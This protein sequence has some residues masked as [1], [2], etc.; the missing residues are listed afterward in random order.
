MDSW[1]LLIRGG[2]IVAPEGTRRADIAIAGDKI[3]E[4]AADL[5]RH[6]STEIDAGG[7]HVF[8]GL[9]DA[10][11]HFN[12]PGR[13]EW[14][15][16]STGSSALAAGGGTCFFDMP[17]NSS[18]PTLDAASFHAKRRAAEAASHTDFALWGGVTP[19]NLDKLP[20]L[21][22][23]GVIGFKAF[24]AD[25]G[26]EDFPRS[27]DET[28]EQG[29]ISAAR[30]GLPVAVHAEDQELTSRL[31]AEA[32]AAERRGV[33]DFLAS[34]PI[35]AELSAVDR[36]IHIA[37]R[38]GCSLHVVHVSSPAAC[39]R[40]ALAK[41]NTQVTCETCP[42]YLAL[43]DADMQRIGAAA[44]CAPPLRSAEESGELLQHLLAGDFD[45]IGSD[46]SPAPESMKRSDDF[47]AVWGG[48]AGVQ[49]TLS[50]LLSLEPAIPLGQIA[51][52][53][54]ANVAKRFRLPGKGQLVTGYDADLA[55]VDL[56]STYTLRREQLLDRHKLSPYIGRK[57]RGVVRRTILRGRTILL[58]G[59]II[60]S[61]GR[62]RGRLVVPSPS[63][64]DP[65]QA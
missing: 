11:V 9:I 44:K 64:H 5:P 48:I 15:G 30:L 26:I 53:T 45:L 2:T 41:A 3:I 18:P 6:A 42:H 24:M 63:S 46:H 1:D 14:E 22:R 12:E 65:H 23:C 16:F 52:L 62:T 35:A 19:V 38:T 17:L 60:Q 59:Q 28:L 49:S 50:L 29:M 61:D 4:I 33:R 31:T 20:E 8:P 21:A 51:A 43:T 56:S 37:E 36:A 58:D 7:L 32:R 55:L 47:F 39:R 25:S 10:H 13:T 57:L 54:S 40:I 34:R 27:D